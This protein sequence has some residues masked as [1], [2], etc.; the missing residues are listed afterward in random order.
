MKM[1]RCKECGKKLGLLE[2]YQHPIL[3]KDF[4][5]CSDCFDSEYESV[6]KWREAVLQYADFFNHESSNNNLQ[7]DWKKLLSGFTKL[8]KMLAGVLIKKEV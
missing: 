1:E 6:A 2:S 3:G 8:R 7:L 4:L 5:L